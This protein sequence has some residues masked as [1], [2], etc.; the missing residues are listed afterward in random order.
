MSSLVMTWVF[1]EEFYADPGEPV[2]QEQ[3]ALHQEPEALYSDPAPDDVHALYDEVPREE[4]IRCLIN[5]L[6]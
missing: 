5:L 4:G 6:A 3:E 1:L 2:Q